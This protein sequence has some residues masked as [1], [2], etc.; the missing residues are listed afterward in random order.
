MGQQQHAQSGAG[1]G[2]PRLYGR[3]ADAQH[4]RGF[5]TGEL[6]QV[7][8]DE[9]LAEGGR[10]PGEVGLEQPAKLPPAQRFFGVLTR[11]GDPPGGGAIAALD[12]FIE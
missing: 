4:L 6:F 7:A 11:V 5:L 10:E 3:H 9:H 1:A 12:H 2:E 8:K